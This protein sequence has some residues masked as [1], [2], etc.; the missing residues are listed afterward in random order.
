[1]NV[2]CSVILVCLPIDIFLE[3]E[4][5]SLAPGTIML[6]TRNIMPLFSVYADSVKI[7]D[8]SDFVVSQYL[9]R[10]C[11]LNVSDQADIPLYFISGIEHSELT[12]ALINHHSI[13]M[14]SCDD[15]SIMTGLSC[16]ALF[17]KNELLPLFL[18][19]CLRGVSFKVRAII[20][21][22]IS[23]NWMLGEIA[24]QLNMSESLLKRKLKGE[25]YSFSRLL[26]EERMRIAV[27]MLYFQ[28]RFK[29]SVAEECGYSSK[30]YFVSVFHR[31]YGE[32]PVKYISLHNCASIL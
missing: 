13:Y 6:V 23:A 10:E 1:M 30:S 15:L 19:G 26:L 9:E 18:S 17:A 24:I 5:I 8:I 14:D 2:A 27:N 29:R 21:T 28:Y 4:K 7:A 31:Y 3:K 32:P 16:L 11:K 25:G 22:D 12:K 20:Q